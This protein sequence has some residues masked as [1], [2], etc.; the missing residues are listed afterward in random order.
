VSWL[1]A[2]V[3]DP[4][5][6]GKTLFA[7]LTQGEQTAY[8]PDLTYSGLA[9][10]DFEAGSMPA[11]LQVDFDYRDEGLSFAGRPDTAFDDRTLIN[12]RIGIESSDGR[13][14]AALW[15]KN[16]GDEKWSGYNYQ[17]LGPMEMHQSPRT[18]GLNVKLNF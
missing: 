17:I 15:G 9:R 1:D 4:S 18:Y 3:S 6:T 5:V 14:V 7:P 12:A 13:W 8:A 10:Y 11:Y 16:L 2:E